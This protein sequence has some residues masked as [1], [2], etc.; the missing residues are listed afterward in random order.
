MFGSRN[1]REKKNLFQEL[2][3][4][5]VMKGRVQKPHD[6]FPLSQE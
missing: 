3:W 1:K 4:K 2:G 5:F 6:L